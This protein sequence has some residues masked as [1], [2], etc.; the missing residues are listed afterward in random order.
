MLHPMVVAG[1]GVMMAALTTAPAASAAASAATTTPTVRGVTRT[2]VTVGGLVGADPIA[3]DADLGAT[4]RF[5]R[6]KRQGRVGGRTVNYLGARSTTDPASLTGLVDAAFAVVP[7]LG[8]SQDATALAREAV[9]FVGVAGS[10]E[11]FGNRWGFGITGAALSSASTTASPAWGV[12]LRALLGGSRAKTVVVVSD[13]DALGAVRAAATNAA[14]RDAGFRV[15]PTVTLSAPPVDAAAVARALVAPVPPPTA[16]VL[17]ATDPVSLGVAQQLA[18]LGYTGT[19]GVGDAFYAPAAPA[20]AAGLTVLVPIAPLE[21]DT[22]ALRRM[23]ADVRAVDPAAVISPTVV[24]A[25]YSADFFLEVLR[26]VGR[27]LTAKRFLAVANGGT[28]TYE[29][30]ATIG[31]STWPAMHTGAIPCGALVQSD[32]TRYFLAEPYRCD[33]PVRLPVNRKAR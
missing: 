8:I 4:A 23:V 13:G 29:V 9:P 22:P 11:W 21:A 7:A 28:F 16:V 33:S 14:L 30:P 1:V 32:G 15:L 18:A 17:V 27:G 26:K 6:A 2:I 10:P 31:R 19:V 3:K 12:Q 24:E 20:I 25:Y 5:E